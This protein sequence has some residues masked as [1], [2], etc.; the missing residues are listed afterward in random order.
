MLRV[1]QNSFNASDTKITVLTRDNLTTER[2][3]LCRPELVI[4]VGGDGTCLSAS[5]YVC[6]LNEWSLQQSN[7]TP[8]LCVNSDPHDKDDCDNTKNS[9]RAFGSFGSFGELCC[10]TATNFNQYLSDFLNDDASFSLRSRILV[11]LIRGNGLL[12]EDLALNDVLVAHKDPAVTS[13]FRMHLLSSHNENNG[14]IH[15]NDNNNN[16]SNIPDRSSE[17]IRSSGFRVCTPTGSTAAML[18]AGGFVMENKDEE[19]IQYM[20]NID[21]EVKL[22]VAL[23]SPSYLS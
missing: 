13:R 9:R 15:N 18:S 3:N 7:S 19:S 23:H 17:H 12:S 20:V 4:S 10:C 22:N 8:L 2:Y 6:G 11:Q 21:V 14:M 1:L 5:R 16:N